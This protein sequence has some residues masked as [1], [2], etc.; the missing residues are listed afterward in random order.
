MH[1]EK[2]IFWTENYSC[3]FHANYIVP[4]LVLKQK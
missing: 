3:N 4:I 1:L 2:V